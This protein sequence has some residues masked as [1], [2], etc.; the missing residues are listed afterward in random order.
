MKH[1]L[2]ILL[3]LWQF[4]QNIVGLLVLLWLKATRTE[5]EEFFP[6]FAKGQRFF[7][8]QGFP[9]GIS[10][11]N[12]VFING[13]FANLKDH[14]E[15][16]EYGHCRQSRLLGP[17]YLLVIGL[18]SGVWAAIYLA[19]DPDDTSVYYRFYTERWADALGGVER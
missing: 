19:S 18:P 16:H 1:I 5:M 8:V 14:K 6:S 3:Y 17:L 12:Y 11:G 2:N 7:Y 10:L 4:P 15:K 13:V 9:G